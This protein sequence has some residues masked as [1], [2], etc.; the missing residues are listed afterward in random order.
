EA[1]ILFFRHEVLNQFVW[2]GREVVWMAP[3]SYLICLLPIGVL[4]GLPPLRKRAAA[5]TALVLIFGALITFL[6]LDVAFGARLHLIARALLALGVGV[7]AA[8]FAHTRREKF[9]RLVKRGTLILAPLVVLLLLAGEGWRIGSESYR[10]ARLPAARAGAPN[11]VFIILD[12][13]RAASMSLYGYEQPTTPELERFA[14]RGVTFDR[15][16]ATAPWTLPSHASMFT[17]HYPHEMSASWFT[18][19]GER[20]V[21]LAETM[22][23]SGYAT[24]AFM[25]NFYFTTPESGL[26]R[27]FMRFD[28][29][30]RTLYQVFLSSALGQQL[31]NFRRGSEVNE[32][33]A[34]RKPADHINREFLA[35]AREHREKP[36]F[37]VLNYFDAHHPYH[38]VEPF[39]EKFGRGSKRRY[40][41][42]IA[43]LDQQLGVLFNE[44]AADG[45]L[46]NTVVVITS[47]HG[48]LFGEGAPIPAK[49]ATTERTCPCGHGGRPFLPALNVPLLVVGPGAPAGVHVRKPVSLRDLPATV[50]QLTG[51]REPTEFPGASLA[52]YWQPGTTP[53]NE[54]PALSEARTESALRAGGEDAPYTYSLVAD[55]FH[56]IWYPDGKEQL[57]NHRVDPEERN[58]LGVSG[59]HPELRGFRELLQQMVPGVQSNTPSEPRAMTDSATS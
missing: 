36:F 9:S 54:L 31:E 30:P 33:R 22:Q 3:I 19:L 5:G 56:Y 49:G 8:R 20:K 10:F 26:A 14:R 16:I 48:E 34:D 58:D 7:Q 46:D 28:V 23:K 24:A 38:S 43:Y 27:G 32:R 17:G 2:A 13:V 50:L 15:A 52:R 41:G 40:A 21:T 42:A 47:D 18:P 55:S 51:A 12:T 29:Y 1:G 35:W 53:S 6:L 59:R 11:V 57:F 25:A 44:L 4:F 45:M 37:A 39:R